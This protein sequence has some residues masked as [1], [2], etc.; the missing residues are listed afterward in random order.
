MIHLLQSENPSKWLITKEGNGRGTV[1][2]VPGGIDCGT[3]C[4]E[5]YNDSTQVILTAIP[6]S[7]SSFTG[8]S[9][10]SDCEDGTVTMTSDVGC[11]A[12][13]S[14][15]PWPMSLPAVVNGSQQ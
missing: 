4:D 11:T 12:N 2:S 5:R 8:W 10:H 13:F 6:E 1:T 7:G 14:K 15:F 9:G 3:D